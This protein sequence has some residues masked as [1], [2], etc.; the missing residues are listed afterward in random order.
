MATEFQ[1]PTERELETIDINVNVGPQH[2]ATHGVFRMILTVDGEQVVDVDP[3]IGYMHRGAEKLSE[4]CDYRQGIGY[5]DR[6]DYLAQF[7]TELCYCLAVEKLAGLAV[8][9][10]A[11][12]VR[13]ILAELNRIASHYM[14]MGAFGTDLGLFGT[15]FMYSFRDRETIQDFFEEITGERLMYN[16]FRP[17][18]LA[19]DVPEDFSE[20]CGQV[21]AAVRQGI[22]DIDGLMTENEVTIARCRGLSVVSPQDAINWGMTGP[23]LRATGLKHDLR[24]AEPYSIYDR[25]EFD[26]PTGRQGDVYDRYLVRLEEMRQSARIVEQALAKLPEG[27]IMAEGMKRILRVPPGEVYLRTESP[28][29]EYGIY[30]VSKGG[31]KPY[32][33]KV[34]AAAF[35]N[36]SALRAMAVGSYVA[37]TIIILGSIDIVLCE[38]DR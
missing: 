34:R 6:T 19:W 16:Y 18:G 7:N 38:V 11:E 10:R 31:E 4:N 23:M 27:P 26:V 24:R 8:P 28:R 22:D 32:R 14:F 3:V 37:D 5:Q 35:S 20:R 17:G 2:P 9:E 36:L 1:V 25:F 21:L 30:L 12:Y 29:G 15:S 13:V 33:L